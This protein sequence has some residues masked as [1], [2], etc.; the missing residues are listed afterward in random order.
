MD[1]HEDHI[2]IEWGNRRDG[3]CS[4]AKYPDTEDAGI[5]C[6]HE[7]ETLLN[8]R[9]VF[10]NGNAEGHRGRFKRVVAG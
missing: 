1:I 9:I 8:P 7:A 3:G 6:Q 5:C 10:D 4:C 2:G